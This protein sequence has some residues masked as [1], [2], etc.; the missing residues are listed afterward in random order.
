MPTRPAAFFGFWA[1]AIWA[2]MF[3][4]APAGAEEPLSAIDWLSTSVSAPAPS[5]LPQAVVPPGPGITAEPI[6][7]RPLDEVNPDGLGLA[8]PERAG[9]PR[10]LWGATPTADLARMIRA[11]R[12]DTLP[13]VQSLLTAI[14]LA[15]LAPPLDSDASGTLFLAR[16]DK[17]LDLGAL[18]PAVALL[19]MLDKPGPEAFRRWFDAALLVGE[20][21]HACQKMNENP[22]IA[23][24]IPAR[25]YCQARLGDW[26]SADLTLQSATV[27]GQL[28]PDEVALL[29]RFLDP[30]MA[31]G[32]EPLPQPDRPSPLVLRM[33]EAIGEPLPTA[34]LPLAFATSDLRTNTGWKARIEAA[35]RLA[36]V[37]VVEPNLLL[38]L[39]TEL[40]PSASGGV[41]DRVAAIQALDEALTSGADAGPALT[42]AWDAMAAA[43]LEVPF[44]SMFA[45]RLG[46]APL[47]GAAAHV[48][49]RVALIAPDRTAPLPALADADGAERFL[50]GLAQG[51]VAGLPA[52]EQL[53]AAIGAAFDPATPLDPAYVAL[54]TGDRRGEALLTAIGDVTNGAKGDLRKVTA[55]LRLFRELGLETHARR[56]A[57]E[58]M[59][60][61]RRG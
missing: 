4:V 36:R 54:L 7:V 21:D 48:A 41:W 53:G 14:I 13:A 26:A 61:E 58:L 60:L 39:Y 44:A 57:L 30:E 19:E 5:D 42:A 18:D 40:A 15:E 52:P 17:L 20:E 51:N 34:T 27:L 11:E 16:I 6:R 37:G 25:I 46:P 22:E 35:E 55:G 38:G 43:E 2:L 12:V 56:T 28:Q 33:M 23:P 45:E 59:I 49:L 1:P 24:T 32:A 3:P 47:T 8:P 29:T 10:E 9:L 50:I 31:D